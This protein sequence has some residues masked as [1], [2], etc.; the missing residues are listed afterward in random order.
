MIKTT[1]FHLIVKEARASNSLTNL[2]DLVERISVLNSEYE[3]CGYDL[4]GGGGFSV[5]IK[6]STCANKI[7]GGLIYHNGNWQIHT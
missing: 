3:I 5:E 7:Y 6:N 4:L 2:M 1:D